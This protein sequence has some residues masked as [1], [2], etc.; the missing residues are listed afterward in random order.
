MSKRIKLG[1]VGN[2]GVGKSS[3][4]L[5]FVNQ[6]FSEG[7]ITV[8]ADFLTK[9][10]QVEGQTVE[11]EIRDTAGQERFSCVTASY[12]KNLDGVLF[13][14]DVSDQSSFDCIDR[15]IE[16]SDSNV[17]SSYVKLIVGNKIDLSEKVID[18][19]TGKAAA[20]KIGAQFIQTSAKE[21]TNVDQAFYLLASEIV[22]KTA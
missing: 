14:Y 8:G 17:E 16:Q 2:C 13:V 5:Q 3:L 22:K 9:E 12:F 18:Y 10:V 4:L 20:D 15:W 6:S 11:L 21:A 1:V 19:S 7:Y